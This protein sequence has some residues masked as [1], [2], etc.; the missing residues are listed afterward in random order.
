M[1]FLLASKYR[2]V[3]ILTLLLMS[4]EDDMKLAY[5]LYDVL[6]V[7]KKYLQEK[8]MNHYIIKY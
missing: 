4:N 5:V 1:N 3:D 7:E 6:K 2:K 8:H